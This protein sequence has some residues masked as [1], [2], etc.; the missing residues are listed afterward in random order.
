MDA[1]GT[2]ELMDVRRPRRRSNRLGLF[3]VLVLFAT[4]L[5][6]VITLNSHA[7]EK[8]GQDGANAS[9]CIEK[10][11]AELLMVNPLT[12]HYAECTKLAEG[13][14]AVRISKQINGEFHEITAFQHFVDFLYEVEDYLV[15]LGYMF[16]G[17]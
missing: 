3:L 4:G 1:I 13:R 2:L 7:T 6:G 15:N 12:K 17:P 9:A 5:Y 8:H 16:M 14:F 11:G 10:Y